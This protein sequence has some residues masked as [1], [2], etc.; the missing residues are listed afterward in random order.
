MVNIA[1][2]H[3]ININEN[4]NSVEYNIDR[5]I[6]VNSTDDL[7]KYSGSY[8]YISNNQK[9]KEKID[10]V[11]PTHM[12]IPLYKNYKEIIFTNIENDNIP[13]SFFDAIMLCDKVY[14][15]NLTKETDEML[16][17]FFKLGDYSFDY[18]SQSRLENFA[19]VKAFVKEKHLPIN[20]AKTILSQIP[21]TGENNERRYSVA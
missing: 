11:L 19:Q 13:Q 21:K 20:R 8:H 15:E 2:A 3:D 10:I 18:N 5:G 1:N 12:L 4:T 17:K 7:K 9:L 16:K 6:F 14:C